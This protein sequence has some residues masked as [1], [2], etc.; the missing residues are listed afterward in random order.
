MAQDEENPFGGLAL[1]QALLE[2]GVAEQVDE[3][4][5]RWVSNSREEAVRNMSNGQRLTR[6]EP[7]IFI[8][9]STAILATTSRVRFNKGSLTE[10]SQIDPQVLTT[11]TA[12]QLSRKKSV[13]HVTPN[14][15]T[16]L[17]PADPLSFVA[18]IR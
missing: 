9:Y 4:T 8:A 1:V 12:T 14:T 10:Q 16:N 11:T 15:G 17:E 5:F 13:P 2:S 7:R 3:D 6:K 18:G